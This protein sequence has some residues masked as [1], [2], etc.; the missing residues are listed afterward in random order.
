MTKKLIEIKGEELVDKILSGERDFTGIHLQNFDVTKNERY[1]ELFQYLMNHKDEFYEGRG[2]YNPII[3]DESKL[4][5]V[6]LDRLYLRSLQAKNSELT[7]CLFEFCYLENANFNGST[8][9]NCWFS[10]SYLERVNFKEAKIES[11][12]F[13]G[14]YLRNATFKDAE[15]EQ[16]KFR[17]ANLTCVD[18]SCGVKYRAFF[19]NAILSCAQIG[20]KVVG[21]Y[22]ELET[23]HFYKTNFA[24]T[25]YERNPAEKID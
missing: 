9:T 2:K 22:Y 17:D 1:G 8:I 14:A 15:I 19:Q 10:N 25:F 16:A 23:A 4:R 24:G 7:S 18:L 3:L 13:E 21:Q 6:D 20:K 5:D 11:A 12:D